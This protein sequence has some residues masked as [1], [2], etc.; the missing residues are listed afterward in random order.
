MQIAESMPKQAF[1]LDELVELGH[2]S[3]SYLYGEIAEKRLRAVKRGK[4]IVV[5]A[6]DLQAWI[7]CLPEAKIRKNERAA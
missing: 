1:S 2:G 6:S 5:L 7:A 4:R 3:R